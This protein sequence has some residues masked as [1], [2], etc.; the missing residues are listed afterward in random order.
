MNTPTAPRER[1]CE[2]RCELP[3]LRAS[4]ARAGFWRHRL[5]PCTVLDIDHGGMGISGRDIR[6][7]LGSRV[8]LHIEDEDGA[9]YRVTGVVSYCLS[10]EMRH[11]YGIVFIHVPP[12]LDEHIDRLV[13]SHEPPQGTAS[14]PGRPGLRLI[15]GT[16][17]QALPRIQAPYLK[18]QVRRPLRA[19]ATDATLINIGPGGLAFR[20]PAGSFPLGSPLELVLKQ[21]GR[22]IALAG[23]ITYVQHEEACPRYGVAFTTAPPAELM[24]LMERQE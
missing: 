6:L 19:V 20:M 11:Q 17:R 12:E 4:V 16:R 3:P 1:R 22:R 2:Q 10:G 24:R 5:Q 23:R 14:Q 9:A 21:N 8:H 13:G 18:L 15:K 7:R